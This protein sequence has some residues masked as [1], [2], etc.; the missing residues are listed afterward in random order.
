MK[1][2]RLETGN[3]RGLADGADDFSSRGQ[4]RGLTVVVGPR[5]SGKTSLLEAIVLA[6][7][8]L[9]AYGLVPRTGAWLRAG[10]ASGVLRATFTLEPDEQAAAECPDVT[11]TIEIDLAPDAALPRVAPA[12]RALFERF[13]FDASVP[14]LEYFHDERSLGAGA[15]T[16]EADE[17]RLR[18]TRR[19]DKYAGLLPAMTA[20]SVQDGGRANEE[21]QRHGLLLADD[22]PDSLGHYWSAIAELVPELRLLG[23]APRAPGSA[24]QLGFANKDGVEV[25]AEGLSA[26]QRQGVLFAATFARLGL[27]RSIVLIDVPELHLHGADHESFLPRLV[28]LGGDNQIIVATGSSAMIGS[29]SREETLVLRRDGNR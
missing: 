7:E 22:R 21:A 15:P 20:L 13:A 11:V 17:R 9:G 2:L 12:V 10:A 16:T 14:K 28:R 27:A 29:A 24:P 3:V 23:A 18:P 4:P 8:S 6:K 19:A 5:A 26:G 25:G 1:I